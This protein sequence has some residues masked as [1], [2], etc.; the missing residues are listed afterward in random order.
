MHPQWLTCLPVL[1]SIFGGEQNKWS[2]RSMAYPRRTFRLDVH[3]SPQVYN[4]R[5]MQLDDK[6]TT[7]DVNAYCFRRPVRKASIRRGICHT[8]HKSCVWAPVSED[9]LSSERW[10]YDL[11]YEQVVSCFVLMYL[12][13]TAPTNSRH[14]A[15]AGIEY[16]FCASASCS[17][18]FQTERPGVPKECLNAGVLCIQH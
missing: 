14:H 17:L 1:H 2:L 12:W 8:S 6:Q 3:R 5:S 4:N 7:E 9:I 15:S 18:V 10:R 13:F 16:I 11:T